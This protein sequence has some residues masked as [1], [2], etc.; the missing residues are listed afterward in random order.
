MPAPVEWLHDG[1]EEVQD[2]GREVHRVAV[3]AP[4]D[5]DEQRD[6]RGR[7]EQQAAHGR[8]SGRQDSPKGAGMTVE[9]SERVDLVEALTAAAT[10]ASRDVAPTLEAAAPRLGLLTLELEIDTKGRVVGG[11]AWPQLRLSGATLA[12]ARRG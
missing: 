7:G 8:T 5:P 4:D 2:V 3:P 12:G 9:T 6:Q 11:V 10:A 1:P